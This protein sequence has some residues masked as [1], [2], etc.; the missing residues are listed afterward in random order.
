MADALA[1]LQDR[2]PPFPGRAAQALIE[3]AL[4]QPIDAVFAAFEIE[5]LASA[6]VA[7]VHGAVLHDGTPVVVKVVR[8]DIKPLIDADLALLKRLA[9]AL[10]RHSP[11]AARLH[12][13][14][15]V[16]DYEHTIL[17][18]L[19]LVHEAHNTALAH[20]VNHAPAAVFVDERLA[21]DNAA[22]EFLAT[23]PVTRFD[24]SAGSAATPPFRLLL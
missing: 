11:D 9:A 6:S 19:D 12:V 1:G 22:L 24:P 17:R 23:R 16:A 18:E 5:P 15:I 4:G 20:E 21:S 10:E 14:A 2:V 3:T 13:R 7:Q 8:P